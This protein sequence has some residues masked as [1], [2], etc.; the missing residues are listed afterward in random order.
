MRVY[1]DSSALLRWLLKQPGAIERF[2]EWEWAVASELTRIEAGRTLDRMRVRGKLTDR[3]VAELV[4]SLGGALNRFEEI[5]I[6]RPILERVASPF[7]TAIGTLDAIH[8][9][10]ALL[11]MARRAVPLTFL[12]HDRQ[13]AIAAQAS[14]LDVW[15]AL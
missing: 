14:G 10:T 7:P 9:S 13:L 8:L 2:G 3:D 4:R 1:V 15:P 6:E 5:R 12:T 11:W